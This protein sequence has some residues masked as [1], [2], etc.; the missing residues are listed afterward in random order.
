MLRARTAL[1]GLLVFLAVPVSA[2]AQDWLVLQ[3][4]A[5]G[6]FWASDSGSRLLTRNEGRPGTVERMRLFAGVAPTP[7]L[8]LVALGTVEAG[9]AY[10]G[11]ENAELEGLS[12]RIAAARWLVLEGGKL[13]SPIGAFAPP[14]CADQSIDR[15]TGWLSHDVSLGRRSLGCRVGIRLADRGDQPAPGPSR[16]HSHAAGEAATGRGR[17]SHSAFR[18]PPGMSCTA[19]NVS[20]RQHHAGASRRLRVE[21]LPAGGH[22]AGCPGEP[23]VSR[24]PRG[25]GLLLVR[26]SNRGQPDEGPCV[27]PGAQ[28][29]LDAALLYRGPVPE[30]RVS[31]C[32]TVGWKT[33]ARGGRELLRRRDRRRFSTGTRGP[34]QA[35]LSEG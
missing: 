8:Q 23:R 32:E 24:F 9:T 11:S 22:R 29:H 13:S 6:E 12:L 25:M 1:L 19:R 27:L 33:L 35:Q 31:V 4:I 14:A 30:E 7:A 17:G 34:G 16:V 21:R 10:T 26:R 18:D 15:R 28:V 5:E 20:Q 2:Q 3:G